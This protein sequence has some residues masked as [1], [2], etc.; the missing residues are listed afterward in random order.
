MPNCVTKRST[1]EPGVEMVETRSTIKGSLARIK[2][3]TII[4]NFEPAAV[5]LCPPEPPMMMPF[6]SV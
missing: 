2:G 6:E 4:D 5:S 1:S 3:A